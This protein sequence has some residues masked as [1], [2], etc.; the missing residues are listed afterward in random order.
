MT[1]YLL[2]ARGGP[3]EPCRSDEA[4]IRY[5]II[6]GQHSA[7]AVGWVGGWAEKVAGV[8]VTV[9]ETGRGPG[10][11]QKMA[12]T[13]SCPHFGGGLPMLTPHYVMAHLL[14]ALADTHMGMHPPPPQPL[15]Q[16]LCDAPWPT[17]P[18]RLPP[19]WGLQVQQQT[20]A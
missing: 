8:S 16:P 15:Q 7:G 11:Q 19:G 13:L 12:K 1:A 20:S 14:P 9:L 2:D 6:N 3:G 17:S 4:D 18:Y 5:N 10:L